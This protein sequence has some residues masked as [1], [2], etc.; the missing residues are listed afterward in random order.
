[1]LHVGLVSSCQL[2]PCN[3]PPA[4]SV[5]TGTDLDTETANCQALREQLETELDAAENRLSVFIPGNNEV[6]RPSQ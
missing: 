5:G 2:P 4:D 1:M 3:M 6:L